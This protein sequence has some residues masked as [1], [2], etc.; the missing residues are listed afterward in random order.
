M[1]SVIFE[2]AFQIIYLDLSFVMAQ[3]PP[4]VSLHSHI[5]SYTHTQL[6]HAKV[7]LDSPIDVVQVKLDKSVWT[8]TGSNEF[9]HHL[10]FEPSNHLDSQSDKVVLSAPAVKLE[11]KML[12]F[13]ATAITAVFGECLATVHLM[14]CCVWTYTTCTL[15]VCI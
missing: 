15:Y 7:L 2:I 3:N 9:F 14:L 1:H 11:R 10:N 6:Q 8:T 5:P 4:N 12:H 13:A